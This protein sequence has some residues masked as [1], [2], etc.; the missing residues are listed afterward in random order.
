MLTAH[1]PLSEWQSVSDRSLTAT[2]LG[3]AGQLAWRLEIIRRALGDVPMPLTSFIRTGSSGQHGNGTAIDFEP[4]NHTMSAREIFDR[5]MSV[6]P[7][8][9]AFGQLIF[10]PF[11]DGHIHLSLR[12]GTRTNEILIADAAEE[13][14]EAPTPTLIAS[15]PGSVVA[16]L[17]A[18]LLIGGA[19]WLARGGKLT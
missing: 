14:Y 11:S 2:D 19:L 9:G 13:R 4:V 3:N 1:F 6:V 17:G 15:L 12:T 5:V 8:L 7:E 18:V 16:G 10:Y